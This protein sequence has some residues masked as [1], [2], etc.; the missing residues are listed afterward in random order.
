LTRTPSI[1]IYVVLKALP[2]SMLLAKITA[3]LPTLIIEHDEADLDKRI[4]CPLLVP[5]GK[6]GIIEK[7]FDIPDIW[8]K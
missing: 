1:S 8:Q 3:L 7:H 5:W 2:L 4:N 6:H